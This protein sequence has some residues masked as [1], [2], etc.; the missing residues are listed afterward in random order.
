VF[1][2]AWSIPDA[3]EGLGFV[4]KFESILDQSI[5][6]QIDD[7]IRGITDCYQILGAFMFYC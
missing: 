6:Q 1:S 3:F 4:P 7:F 5:E 2:F